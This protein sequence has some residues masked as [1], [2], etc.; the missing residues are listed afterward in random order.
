MWPNLLGGVQL[1]HQLAFINGATLRALRER[2]GVS[3]EYLC[4]KA[5]VSCKQLAIWEQ[6]SA[7]DY[8]TIRQAEKM[9]KVLLIPLAGLYL[10]PSNLPD[11]KAPRLINK[12]RIRNAREL[13]DSALHL[14]ACKLSQIRSDAIG[15][16]VETSATFRGFSIPELSG[17]CVCDAAAVRGWMELSLDN[18]RR[19]TSARQLYLALRTRLEERG[20]LVAQF[21]GVEVEELR[22]IAL[23][24]DEL[25]VIGVN[26]KDRWPAKC[27]SVLHEL[28]HLSRRSSACCNLI[29]MDSDDEEEVFC[30]SVAGEF[31]FSRSCAAKE[32]SAGLDPC[33]IESIERTAKSYSVSRDVVAR[34]LHDCGYLDK[35]AYEELLEIFSREVAEQKEQQRKKKALGE[36]GGWS[37]PHERVVAD[38][39]GSLYCGL[40]NEGLSTGLFSER[41]ACN[42]FGVDANKLEKV[43]KEAL[44]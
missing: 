28:V 24:Y 26:A 18:Q 41:D 38:S 42:A 39:L 33:D 5:D 30:N 9:A 17:D 22:G 25:P 32:I 43:F 40:V 23:Y 10:E 11:E 12:R 29:N 36:R 13:D 6:S 31:L 7:S 20:V 35:P 27:F 34:R 21:D 16:A 4:R 19:T 8:P 2:R 37:V 15:I 1:S 3:P 14:A 44:L